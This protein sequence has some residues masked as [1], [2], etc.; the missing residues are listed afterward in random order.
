MAALNDIFPFAPEFG[1]YVLDPTRGDSDLEN[2]LSYDSSV[3]D[4]SQSLS[5]YSTFL[6]T[7]VMKQFY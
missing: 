3:L 2:A 6:R 4:F 7:D 1:A 5:S